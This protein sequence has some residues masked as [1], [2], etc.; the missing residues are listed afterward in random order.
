[1][2]VKKL[3]H[4]DYEI[5]NKWHVLFRCRDSEPIKEGISNFYIFEIFSNVEFEEVES[6]DESI[7]FVNGQCIGE[8]RHLQGIKSAW[9]KLLNFVQNYDMPDREIIIIFQNEFY[10]KWETRYREWM[11]NMYADSLNI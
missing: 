3:V 10:D 2:I 1:M 11:D 5:P 7:P 8:A 6:L 4:Y 9:Y